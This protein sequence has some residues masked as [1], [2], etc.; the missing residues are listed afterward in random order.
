MRLACASWELKQGAMHNS[1]M[2]WPTGLTLQGII[3]ADL[4]HEHVPIYAPER[5]VR[6]SMLFINNS[7]LRSLPLLD[8]LLNV[9]LGLLHGVQLPVPRHPAIVITICSYQPL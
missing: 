7:C 8:A 9:R 2:P 4:S 6:L 3:Y 1:E 5:L